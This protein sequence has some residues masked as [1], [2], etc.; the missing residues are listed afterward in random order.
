MEEEQFDDFSSTSAQSDDEEYKPSYA[1]R[2]IIESGIKG[3]KGPA[4]Q[5]DGSEDKE[6]KDLMSF[7]TN[8]SN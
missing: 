6:E 1:V 5:F 8:S 2:R 4:Y 3:R 7:L